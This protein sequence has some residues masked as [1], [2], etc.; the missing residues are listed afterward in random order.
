MTVEVFAINNRVQIKYT[1]GSAYGTNIQMSIEEARDLLGK[2]PEA[3]TNAQ[4][5][6]EKF[7]K[8]EGENNDNS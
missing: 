7:F 8:P 1:R 4:K 5:V 3:I 2:L 6:G